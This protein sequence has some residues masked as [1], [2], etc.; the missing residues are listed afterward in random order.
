[1]SD[2]AGD[3]GRRVKVPGRSQ[4]RTNS[5]DS[6]SHWV[7]VGCFCAAR[8]ARQGASVRHA[9]GSDPGLYHTVAEE[10]QRGSV[11]YRDAWESE[12]PRRFSTPTRQYFRLLPTPGRPCGSAGYLA[13]AALTSSPAG[14]TLVFQTIDFV[15]SLVLAAW[16][17]W[18]RVASAIA[19][20]VCGARFRFHCRL[21]QPRG[22]GSRGQHA[23]KYAL[24]PAI[25]VVL[26]GLAAVQSRA[27]AGSSGRRAGAVAALSRFPTWPASER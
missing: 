10:I 23:R 7:A 17:S 21:C 5:I 15:Y 9:D 3:A 19:R 24:G 8:A 20:S 22:V 12:A 1:L 6:V 4:R 27:P 25:G 11:P 18:W 14:G 26:A 2:R 13:S 16:C